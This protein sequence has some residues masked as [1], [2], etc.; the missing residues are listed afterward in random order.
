MKGMNDLLW[1]I[2]HHVLAFGIFGLLFAE[3]VALRATLNAAQ[4][5]RIA[6]MD[7]AY[8][9]LAML[10]VIFGFLRANLA[11]KG[12]PY[13]SHN[14]FFW[15]KIATFAAIAL[16]SLPPTLAFSRWKRGAALPD[17]AAL[18]AV[19]RYLHIELTLFVLLPIFAAAMARGYG[20]F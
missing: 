6:T 2:A 14:T 15:A 17:A 18:R 11:A 9:A 19:R 5:R 8:G 3:F 1:A 20:E 10:L 7:L 13:Y 16:L 4:I 12:W